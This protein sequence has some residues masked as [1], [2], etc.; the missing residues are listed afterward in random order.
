MR[1]LN[2]PLRLVATVVAAGLLVV[3][4]VVPASAAGGPNL[5]LGKATQ[6]STTTAGHAVSAV[7]DGDQ[8][9]YWE[10]ANN[11]FP[12]WARIDLGTATSVDQIV[13]KVPAPSAWQT[14]TQTLS[15]QG[16]ADGTNY[17]TVVASANY[18]FNPA[19]G[20]TVTIN[21]AAASHRYWRVNITAN[22]GW[23]AG[24][25]S[26]FEIYGADG[27]GG[28]GNLAAGR[29]MTG[30][31]VAQNYVASNAND[32]NQATYWESVNNV[33]PEWLQV[34]LG[35]SVSVNRVVLKLPASGWAT[36]T[37]TLAV[38]GSTNGSS[39]TDIVGSAGYVFNPAGGNTVTIN[40][41]TA[42]TRYV[43]LNITGNTGWAAGQISEF[44]V[45]GPGG[46]V[47][48]VPPS[49]PTNLAF[50]EQTP[51]QVRLTWT[52]STDNVGVTGYD[53]YANNQFR[54]SVGNVTTYTDTQP[55]SATVTYFVRAKD[56]AG[57]PSANSNSVTRQGQS[58]D[59]QDPSAPG[60]LA[61]TQPASG[62]IRLTWT[63]STDNVGVTGYDVYANNS[64]RASV[65]GNVLT[66]T[67]TQ[68]DS[69][70][71]TYV[72][73]AKDAAGN[74][75]ADSNSVTRTG[76]G[77]P[78]SNLALGKEMVES[79]H[80]H[81]FVAANANDNNTA[82][83]WE[84]NS[85]AFPNTLTVKL[86]ANAV[87]SSVVVKLNP[88]SEWG[89]RTQN[90]QVLGRE[91][92]ATGYSN[93]VS[94]ANYTFNPASGGNSVTINLNATVADVQLRFT[95]NTGA[96]GGQV[97]EFQ[98]FGVPA[99][100]P[101]LTVTGVSWTPTS[102]NETSAITLSA[103]VRNAG[104]AASAADSVNF[105]LGGAL[106]GTATLPALAVN[107]TA[108]VTA[109]IGT[110]AMG[111]YEVSARADA[112]NTVFE[113]NEANNVLVASSP[114]VVAQAPGPD[115]QVTGITS[116][117]PNP[118]VGAQV[119]FTVAVNNRGTTASGVTTVTRLS[120]GGTT[121]NTNTASI[122]AGATANVAITGS[123]TATSGGATIT[124][125]A[126]ATNVLTE[127]NEGNNTLSQSIVVGR[128]AAVP[129]VEYEAESASYQGTLLT[130][131]PLRT[132]GHTN[133]ATESS[134]RQSVRLNNT[135][136]F[137]EFTSTNQANSIVVRNSIPDAPGGGGTEATISLYIN[138]TFAQK[139]TLSSRH[140]WLY[141]NTDQ[142]EGLTNTPQADARRM[143][144]ESH[145]LLSQ[146]YPAGTRFRLQRDA[147]DNATFYIIDLIDLEQVAPAASQPAGCTSITQYGAVPND[148]L[149]DTTAIQRAVTDDQNGVISCV[150]IPAGQWRQEKKILTDDPLNRGQFNQVGISNVTIRGAGMWHSQLY[151]LTEPHLAQGSINHP[152]EGNFGFDIDNNVQISDI[153]IFGSGRIRGGDGNAEGGVGLNGRF[154][155]N[156]K[157]SNVWIEHAN[158]GVW[159]GRDF[160]NIP[161]L[162]GPG[163]GLEFSGMR[164]RNTYAD[165]INF[166][167]GTRNSKVFNS[168]FRYTG[169][170]S[171]AVW[172]NK[173][174]KNQAV[175]IA[176]D[177]QFINNTIQLPWRA[178]GIAVYGGY[179]NKIEN[180]LIY[181]TMNYPGIMLATDHDPLP[182]SGT[183]LIANNALYRAGGVFWNEDQE[184]GAITLFPQ[185]P[186][187]PGVTIRDTDIFDSTYD[188]IQFK[189][190]G[191]NM[192]NV[193][194][195]N[196]RIDKS[197]NGAGILAM[198]GAR[199]NANLTN[200]TITNSATGNIVRQP[201]TQFVING[202]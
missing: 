184:F 106:V 51:G 71:V 136:Q 58:V 109:A 182:F 128:G 72:V 117:P 70:T 143:F 1:R 86:G 10:S 157:I 152:H 168:S 129:Y 166:T 39:F 102:P 183:T 148:G 118:A 80:V 123:W 7:N 107:A 99:P 100:N 167:N 199:G 134:G 201:G 76:T 127:T 68:P 31:S 41:T 155:L 133:F 176:H 150:W 8:S 175:D 59:D 173:Y 115:L 60:N 17:S 45:Y 178:N 194:I 170:D 66:Y 105:N 179:G 193:T 163:D 161:D 122:A 174:V 89:T 132:F 53:I 189:T 74:E 37:Q 33:F 18:T 87:V 73:R 40:F 9:T 146:S 4:A 125:T 48:P 171:L 114:L 130:A 169:D 131:D 21:F 137:V 36:R 124:A 200:V 12:Q 13:L 42:V 65:A 90:I 111:S 138:G 92:S 141:G 104:T 98:V 16:G 120:V 110:R 93:L 188:G 153:A 22:T 50:T 63:A 149:D 30:S 32:G 78:G 190:G 27:G 195:T 57:N 83:Y 24:Q 67:D 25:I 158:V 162:W 34:D 6:A 181:D 140:S 29:T 198:S 88:G 112:D 54:A 147:T 15:V 19:T 56:A 79:G 103:T 5:S 202:G 52:A 69:A 14:R 119:T 38:Q 164:I 49:A 116:N 180:N 113:Q 151:T 191:G 185:G 96:P 172:A 26:E 46:T 156:T 20:N 47:D 23:P 84:A 97:A 91:Q 43:R 159:V 101:D 82:T 44:E 77:N 154:G 28:G 62:Q 2:L 187:I 3:G 192:P 55:L 121:L 108:T 75:S 139:L 165:G 85:G 142:P 160:D 186:D 94:A 61:F 64:F 145:A 35:S 197:N 144:D 95:S 135:G 196:V 11:S 177:N 126:D 81:S